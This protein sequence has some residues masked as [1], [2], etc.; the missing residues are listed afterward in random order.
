MGRVFRLKIALF[1]LSPIT[2]IQ[3]RVH[4]HKISWLSLFQTSLKT[5]RPQQLSPRML[6][7]IKNYSIYSLSSKVCY[8]DQWINYFILILWTREEKPVWVAVTRWNEPTRSVLLPCRM[9]TSWTNAQT[10]VKGE[11]EARFVGI[12]FCCGKPVHFSAPPFALHRLIQILTGW[13]NG[14]LDRKQN[15]SNHQIFK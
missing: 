2:K 15:K 4:F 9:I 6:Q 11:K 8:Y 7:T 10:E 1:I 14:N 12:S 5:S 3:Q 13:K